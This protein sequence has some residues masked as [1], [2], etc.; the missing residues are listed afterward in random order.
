[1]ISYT[2]TLVYNECILGKK[3]VQ[4]RRD[5]KCMKVERKHSMTQIPIQ[6]GEETTYK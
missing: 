1:M 2:R 3:Y 6:D 4:E 5:W